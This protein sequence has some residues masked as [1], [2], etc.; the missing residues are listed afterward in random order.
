MII[1]CPNCDSEYDIL[2]TAL[3]EV[4]REVKCAKCNEKWFAKPDGF[5]TPVDDT[6]EEEGMDAEPDSIEE[7]PAEEPQE[8]PQL[9]E[10]E[11]DE[12]N[13]EERVAEEQD[14]E[15]PKDSLD[16]LLAEDGEEEGIDIPDSV[17]PIQDEQIGN[18]VAP[19][20]LSAK[21]AGYGAALLI[22]GLLIGYIFTN[23]NE[24]I[25]AWLPAAAFYEMAGFPAKLKGEGLVVES[26]SA[27]VL[28]NKQQQD[29]LVVKGRVVNLTDSAIEVPKMEAKMRTTNGDGAETWVIDPPVEIIAAGESFS[30]TTDYPGVPKEIGSL[31]LAFIPTLKK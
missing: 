11:S 12:L 25:G 28:K 23:K 26:L 10:Q 19:K 8:E 31:N 5:D 4:G 22:F 21:M 29:V 6:P 24:I 2:E 15:E 9:E 30:F 7:P 3:G 20:S 1:T 13:A 16:A 17:K 18:A 14:P 27:T